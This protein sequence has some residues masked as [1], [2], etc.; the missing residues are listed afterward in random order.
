MRPCVRGV[1]TDAVDVK[2]HHGPHHTYNRMRFA[3][4]SLVAVLVVAAVH[5]LDFPGSVPDFVRASSGGVLLDAKPAFSEEALYQRLSGYGEEGRENYMRRNL[6]VDVVLPL[7]V[8]PALLL[9]M[10]H[11]VKTMSTRRS[12]RWILYSLPLIYVLFD[13]A[14][15]GTAL[16]LLAHFPARIPPA[17]AVL[18][19]LTVIKRV[20]SLLAL[21]VPLLILG[22]SL[23][24]RR[25]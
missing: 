10:Q 3:I 11:A 7:A 9:L 19:F 21:A 13:F 5:A 20:A 12:V 23:V 8:L 16:L 14:E 24:R 22:V 17:A 18:P 4:A 25:L 15:N 1:T 2:Y 6:T